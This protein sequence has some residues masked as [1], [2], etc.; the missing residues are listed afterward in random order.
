MTVNDKANQEQDI[1]KPK[2]LSWVRL[3]KNRNS[4]AF[5]EAITGI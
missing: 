4:L 5:R 2:K 1:S 3:L